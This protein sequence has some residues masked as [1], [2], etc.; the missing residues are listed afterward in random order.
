[1]RFN[2]ITRGYHREAAFPPVT[3]SEAKDFTP[4]CHPERSEG[5]YASAVP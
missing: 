2:F 5:P 3:L 1:M 4:A